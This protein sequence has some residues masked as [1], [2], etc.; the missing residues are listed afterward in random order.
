MEAPLIRDGIKIEKIYIKT[1]THTSIKKISTGPFYSP[2]SLWKPSGNTCHF[3]ACLVVLTLFDSLFF[4]QV[5]VKTWKFVLSYSTKNNSSN[6][7]FKPKSLLQKQKND[8]WTAARRSWAAIFRWWTASFPPRWW[9]E[10]S[11]ID[12]THIQF[13]V[14]VEA[15]NFHRRNAHDNRRFL[16]SDVRLIP[17]WRSLIT[18]C[19]CA[20]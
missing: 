3:P 1:H 17:Q 20:W 7:T 19:T 5:A 10:W 11:S 18:R 8:T 16:R 12:P 9:I 13:T 2:E 14:Q 15:F 4:H 6:L